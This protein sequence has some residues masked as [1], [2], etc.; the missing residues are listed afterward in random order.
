MI[1]RAGDYQELA[2]CRVVI[3]SAGVNQRPGESRLELLGRNAAIFGEVVPS[4]LRHVPEAL[5]IVA[6]NPVDVMTHVTARRAAESGVSSSRVIGSGTTLD[7]A[8]FRALLGRH[9]GV[10]PQHVHAYVL[11]EHGDSEVLAWSAVSI[12]G[13]PL[14]QYCREMGIAITPEDRRRIDEGVRRAAY[15]I[16]AGKSA[17]Y[18]GIGSSL[19]R[20]VQAVLENQ[21]AILSVCSPMSEICGVQDV[22][23]SLPRLIGGSGIIGTIS[24]PLDPDEQALLNASCATIKD[25]INAL[26]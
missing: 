23:I 25:A 3:L 9:L 15:H 2:G 12:G 10:D 16:I 1:V 17:T 26:N 18:Y 7:T 19:A 22:T 11:G 4:V 6:T 21:R 14:A 20:I 13:I 24:L 8:R 5:L